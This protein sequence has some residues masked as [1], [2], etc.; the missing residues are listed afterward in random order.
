MSDATK[1]DFADCILSATKATPKL[2]HKV[3]PC[4]SN[5]RLYQV[6]ATVRHFGSIHQ[7]RSCLRRY[8]ARVH[9][10]ESRTSIATYPATKHYRQIIKWTATKRECLCETSY[11]CL[12]AKGFDFVI[13]HKISKTCPYYVANSPAGQL[14]RC[15][16]FTSV[17]VPAFACDP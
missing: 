2:I 17:T 9:R 11:R 3:W 13:L 8:R 7:S 12:N 10:P 16:A 15:H 14:L 4:H 5:A 6:P 1:R